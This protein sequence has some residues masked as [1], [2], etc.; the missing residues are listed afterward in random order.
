MPP[1]RI[2]RTHRGAGRGHGFQHGHKPARAQVIGNQERAQLRDP[3]ACQRGV[4]QG[5]GMT[6]PQAAGDGHVAFL[7]L[8]GKAPWRQLPRV[9]ERQRLMLAQGVRRGR[10]AVRGPAGVGDA[11]EAL[12]LVLGN[13][14]GQF[15]HAL[16]AAPASGL[17]PGSG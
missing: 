9:R 15:R 5:C 1:V 14:L 8:D 17:Q 2:H 6:Q 4:A 7:P 10:H 16:R 11:G 12:D 3:V 13:L